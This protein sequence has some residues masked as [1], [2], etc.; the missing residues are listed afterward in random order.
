MAAG[1]AK[2]APPRRQNRLCQKYRSKN[3]SSQKYHDMPQIE[4]DTLEEMKCGSHHED[5]SENIFFRLEEVTP[6]TSHTAACICPSLSCRSRPRPMNW[7]LKGVWEAACGAALRLE[8]VAF[9]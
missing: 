6:S 5:A 3:K 2:E 4:T 8:V 1:E 9:P 7:V